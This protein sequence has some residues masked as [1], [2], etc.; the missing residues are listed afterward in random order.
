VHT[1]FPA[2]FRTE[3]QESLPSKKKDP[4]RLTRCGKRLNS[5]S[6]LDYRQKKLV[7]PTYSEL[8]SV[9]MHSSRRMTLFPLSASKINLYIFFSCKPANASP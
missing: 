7:W 2:H 6:L 8:G 4:S 5:A 3:D 1:E 9:W